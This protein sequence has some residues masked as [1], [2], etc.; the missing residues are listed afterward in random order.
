M[1]NNIT[2]P[3]ATG[4]QLLRFLESG[5]FAYPAQ[6]AID[7]RTA[8]KPP[9]Q[10][11]LPLNEVWSVSNGKTFSMLFATKHGAEKFCSSQPLSAGLWPER[12]SVIGSPQPE[13]QAEPVAWRVW[14]PDGANVYQYT[15]DGDGE[16]L[17]TA[18]PAAQ[19]GQQ[20][21]PVAWMWKNKTTGKRG[22]YFEDPSKFYDLT[23]PSAYEWTLLYTTPLAAQ[24]KPL[25]DEQ[26]I[27]E[28]L[29]RYDLA[30]VKTEKGYEVMKLGPITA[31]GIKEGA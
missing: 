1:T 9:E 24:R 29:R 18:Q 12:I 8:L 4:R 7:L 17:Y 25:T 27:A 20:A 15:E 23:K 30:L 21:E 2:L 14:S 6:L 22:V 19:P 26:Q 5:N 10:S 28:A 13:Q 31:H 16:P 3:R 11:F